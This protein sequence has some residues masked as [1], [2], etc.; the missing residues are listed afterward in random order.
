MPTKFLVQM[1]R[2]NLVEP[3]FSHYA[4]PVKISDI[5]E[6]HD[7][8][9]INLGQILIYKCILYIWLMLKTNMIGKFQKYNRRFMIYF[10]Y[11][12]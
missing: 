11:H 10:K 5:K 9:M 12:I 4:I 7:Y 2:K 1:N 3:T 8:A 6:I